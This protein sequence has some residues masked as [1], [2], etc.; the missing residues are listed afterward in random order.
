M[1]NLLPETCFTVQPKPYT[2]D[3]TRQVRGWARGRIRDWD[4]PVSAIG[5]FYVL[6]AARTGPRNRHGRQQAKDWFG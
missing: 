4:P 1:A 5:A 6:G 3:N 2:R